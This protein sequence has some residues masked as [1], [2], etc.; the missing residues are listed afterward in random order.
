MIM[1]SPNAEMFGPALL[2]GA[3]FRPA[4]RCGP[5]LWLRRRRHRI[6]R[7]TS[8]GSMTHAGRVQAR[9]T[10]PS[11]VGPVALRPCCPHSPLAEGRRMCGEGRSPGDQGSAQPPSGFRR[12]RRW[13]ERCPRRTEQ[14][15]RSRP[16]QIAQPASIG[17]PPGIPQRRRWQPVDHRPTRPSGQ[18]A[19]SSNLARNRCP[20]LV[21]TPCARIPA[22]MS[23]G[24]PRSGS[25]AGGPGTPG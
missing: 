13:R 18:L 2:A 1:F 3:L 25:V 6:C 16:R 14:G 21:V 10:R 20:G 24:V 12:S 5:K 23:V 22:R 17:A 15:G 9:E 7:S 19:T 8:V 4:R 11:P